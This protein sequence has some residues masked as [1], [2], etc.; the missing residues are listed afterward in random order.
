LIEKGIAQNKLVFVQPKL[1][2]VLHVVA[3]HGLV[4]DARQCVV[5]QVEEF[6]SSQEKVALERLNPI[7]AKF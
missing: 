1:F 6:Y 2:Q 4:A 7:M 3:N 5:T